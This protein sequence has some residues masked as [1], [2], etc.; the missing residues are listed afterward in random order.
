M[1]D[2]PSLSQI[3]TAIQNKC[4]IAFYFFGHICKCHRMYIY[5]YMYNYF[6][7]NR[8]ISNHLLSIVATLREE[9]Y[10]W[11]I[12]KIKQMSRPKIIWQQNICVADLS[13]ARPN[14]LSP[15]RGL[16]AANSSRRA[17]P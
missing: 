15:E 7:K 13:S 4:K 1:G 17:A 6:S 9:V 2:T 3:E 16:K 5:N 8:I 10:D 12:P 14:P 11:G